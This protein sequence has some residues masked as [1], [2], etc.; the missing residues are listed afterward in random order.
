MNE[1]ISTLVVLLKFCTDSRRKTRVQH[2]KTY[3]KVGLHSEKFDKITV[4][5]TMW[6]T[7][8]W[9]IMAPLTGPPVRAKLCGGNRLRMGW[10]NLKYVKM[11]NM[12]DEN[13][14]FTAWAT[15]ESRVVKW[16]EWGVQEKD[17]TCLWWRRM[18]RGPR[19]QVLWGECLGQ[20]GVVK[21]PV[22]GWK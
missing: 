19:A 2:Q 8:W 20:G 6:Y 4:R 18:F 1:S 22:A 7:N 14:V 12:A 3:R 5:C 17:S 21:G 9:I 10:G 16:Y 15:L 13:D 11:D